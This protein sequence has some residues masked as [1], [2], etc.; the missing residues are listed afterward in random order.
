MVVLGCIVATRC[1]A[2]ETARGVRCLSDIPSLGV[3][4]SPALSLASGKVFRSSFNVHWHVAPTAVHYDLFYKAAT[5]RMSQTVSSV[6]QHITM[7]IPMVVF[8]LHLVCNAI[9]G[10]GPGKAS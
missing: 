1:P 6:S 3:T 2:V 9:V 10:R 5:T 8:Q 7:D 4:A